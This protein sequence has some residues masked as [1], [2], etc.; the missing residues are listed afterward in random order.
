MKTLK[1][2]ENHIKLLKKLY[3]AWSEDEFG[4]PCI[5]SKRPFG[6]SDVISDLAEIL[7]INLPDPTEE[8]LKYDKIAG[9]LMKGYRELQDCLQILCQNLSIEIGTYECDDYD[10][11][12]RKVNE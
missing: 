9:S 3:I 11:N 2:T 10:I 6:N 4:G 8:Y 5:D 7:G 12:W 1:V